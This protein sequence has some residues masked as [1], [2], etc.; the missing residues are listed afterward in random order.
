M[1]VNV[2]LGGATQSNVAHYLRITYQQILFIYLFIYIYY[3]YIKNI[4]MDAQNGN[5]GVHGGI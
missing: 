1:S 2:K 4:D 5:N 3:I